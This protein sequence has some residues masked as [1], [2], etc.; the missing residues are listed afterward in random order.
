MISRTRP[1][2]RESAVAAEKIA[3]AE[4]RRRRRSRPS[5]AGAAAAPSGLTCAPPPATEDTNGGCSTRLCY[6]AAARAA[7]VFAYG[8][9]Q[10]T[11]EARADRGTG[12]GREPP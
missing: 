11:E 1:A 8:Q 3:V 5:S 7:G 10:A 9:H 4:V 2:T 12:A 6:H